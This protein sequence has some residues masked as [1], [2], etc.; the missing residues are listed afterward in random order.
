MS[1]DS[2]MMI[3]TARATLNGLQFLTLRDDPYELVPHHWLEEFQ[4]V[5]Q[6]IVPPQDQERYR[7]DGLAGINRR[8][9]H[10]QVQRLLA[11]Y[12]HLIAEEAEVAPGLS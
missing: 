8:Y 6:A 10:Q 1:Q 5:V 2:A 7:L 3:T 4:Q 11:D 9:L 12:I